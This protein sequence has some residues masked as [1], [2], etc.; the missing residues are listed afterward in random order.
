MKMDIYTEFI[1]YK[2]FPNNV[3][4]KYIDDLIENSNSQSLINYQEYIG[5]IQRIAVDQNLVIKTSIEMEFA[6]GDCDSIDIA[7]NVVIND[8][9]VMVF[10]FFSSVGYGDWISL[11]EIYE[12]L[13]SGDIEDEFSAIDEEFPGCSINHVQS[14]SRDMHGQYYCWEDHYMFHDLIEQGSRSIRDQIKA[15]I[16][17]YG[18]IE[19]YE[20]VQIR[21]DEADERL[22]EEL[23][24]IDNLESFFINPQVQSIDD[25]YLD[26]VKKDPFNIYNLPPNVPNI[27]SDISLIKE[28]IKRVHLPQ[29]EYM[30]R[31]FFED[32]E[33]MLLT[34]QNHP[35]YLANLGSN[36]RNDKDFVK[37]VIV[38][39]PRALDYAGQALKSNPGM[40]KYQQAIVK[41]RTDENSRS[42]SVPDTRCFIATSV[43]GS[44]DHPK[45][46]DFRHYRDTVLMK[47]KIGRFFVNTYYIF[48]PGFVALSNRIPSLKSASRWFL[49]RIHQRVYPNIKEGR[50]F[51]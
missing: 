16:D 4:L 23:P 29:D 31:P 44:I 46:V 18:D 14:I 49:N 45:V 15:T 32:R 43:Y 13:N 34:C 11:M 10:E 37:D 1:E 12:A 51:K 21:A 19:T 24:S 17:K 2:T 35:F 26:F 41:Q 30:I 40:I 3:R 6:E 22:L 7:A 39:N 48:S 5:K 38:K 50:K 9:G 25:I 33:L 27:N 36:Y 47:K 28:V 20:L 42:V 8:Y